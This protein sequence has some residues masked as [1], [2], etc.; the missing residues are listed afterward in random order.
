[1]KRYQELI[2]A[3]ISK[4]NMNVLNMLNSKYFIVSN[5]NQKLAQRNPSA[6]GNAWFV[7]DQMVANA[8]EELAAFLP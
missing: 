2:D 4:G 8:D 5:Q 6:L 3:H 1:M 7:K